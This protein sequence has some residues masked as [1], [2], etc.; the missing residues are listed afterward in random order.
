MVSLQCGLPF[1]INY[2]LTLIYLLDTDFLTAELL[3]TDFPTVV[4]D[5]CGVMKGN[6]GQRRGDPWQLIRES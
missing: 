3:Y 5:V 4:L 2:D 6:V 1:T